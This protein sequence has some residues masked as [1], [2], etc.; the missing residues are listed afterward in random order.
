MHIH[1]V[2]WSSEW[3][4]WEVGQMSNHNWCVG[5]LKLSKCEILMEESF[6]NKF[7]SGWENDNWNVEWHNNLIARLVDNFGPFTFWMCICTNVNVENFISDDYRGENIKFKC[8]YKYGKVWVCLTHIQELVYIFEN[9]GT[10]QS[11]DR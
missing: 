9:W 4:H 2:K 1:V 11:R 6:S 5:R 8:D 3:F 10:S 7:I